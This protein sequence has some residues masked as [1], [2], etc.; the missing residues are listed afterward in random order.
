MVSKR[1][2]IGSD[3]STGNDEDEGLG[4]GY[5][6]FFREIADNSSIDLSIKVR[7]FM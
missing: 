1:R 4:G 2:E 6:N 5:G 7:Y 3:N